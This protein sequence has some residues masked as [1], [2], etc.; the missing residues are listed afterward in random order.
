MADQTVPTFACAPGKPDCKYGLGC[1]RQNPDHWQR[2]N[3]PAEHAFIQQ[4]SGKRIVQDTAEERPAKL[5]KAEGSSSAS[6]AVASSASAATPA[7]VVLV[8]A[9]GAGGTTAK[10][11]RSL[12]EVEF[13][14]RGMIVVRC[15]D[16]PLGAGESRWVTMSAA[17]KGNLAHVAAVVARAAEAHPATPIFL[18][19]ASFG[20]RVLAELL[21]SASHESTLARLG[22]R[23][24]ALICCGYPL[25]K[26]DA[27]EGADPK[28]AAHLLK[29][30]PSVT[31]L[32][33]QGSK[34]EFLGA[35][36]LAAL[37]DVTAQMQGPARI[38][39]VPGGGH[40]VPKAAGL[41][42]LGTT[43]AQVNALV[44]DAI[45]AF[46]REMLATS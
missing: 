26:P 27:P 5:Q 14:A 45:A 28:R 13:R 16:H 15:D 9:P 1:Y 32:F 38:A 20:C 29:L 24:G 12:Q 18:V 6:D 22:V 39:E 43:Q 35:R 25:H 34:D 44:A 2:F 36:G 7:S 33:V 42:A 31:T 17:S 41:K 30:P 37:R 11:M 3:H 40:T 10:D 21:C 46:T 23:T 4:S 8:F 19:G